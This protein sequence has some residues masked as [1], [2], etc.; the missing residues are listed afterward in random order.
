[1]ARI[2][3]ARQ[4]LESMYHE[5][6]SNSNAEKTDYDLDAAQDVSLPHRMIGVALTVLYKTP[7]ATAGHPSLDVVQQLCHALTIVFLLHQGG[8]CLQNTRTATVGTRI[9]GEGH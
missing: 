1:M 5:S 6:P 4:N 8:L 7:T 3:T 2:S 9:R